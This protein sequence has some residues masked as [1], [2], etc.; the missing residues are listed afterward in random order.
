MKDNKDILICSCHS[1]DH[2]L[3]VLYEQNE[4]FPLVYFHIHLNK[5][6]FWE[7]LVY[8]IKYIFG[9]QSKYGAFDEFIFNFDD[10]HKIERIVEHLKSVKEHGSDIKI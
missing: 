2:Q 9:R 10:V 6:P 3:I 1:T 8:G 4:D 7:R 5:R